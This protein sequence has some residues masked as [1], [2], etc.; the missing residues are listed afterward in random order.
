MNLLQFG[1]TLIDPSDVVLA[2]REGEKT[3]L[4]LRGGHDV[5]LDGDIGKAVWSRLAGRLIDQLPAS[6]S[7]A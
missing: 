3:K 4:L 6:E 1:N 5:E 2:E 7:P